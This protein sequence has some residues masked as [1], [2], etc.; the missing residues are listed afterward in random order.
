MQV[1]CHV[2]GRVRDREALAR[3]VGVG[4]VE[5]FRL[6]R[7]LPPLLDHIRVVQRFH[8]GIVVLPTSLVRGRRSG[9]IRQRL[10]AQY[11]CPV[12]SLATP[13]VSRSRRRF[14]AIR[15]VMYVY[16]YIG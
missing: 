6:P 15:K 8:Q 9:A 16:T 12:S 4:V 7:L 11:G 1:A 10:C 13:K 5:A 3:I 14:V 2:R